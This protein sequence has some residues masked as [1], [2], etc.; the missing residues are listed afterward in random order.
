SRRMATPRCL[1]ESVERDFQVTAT[2]ALWGRRP[3]SCEVYLEGRQ[4]QRRNRKAPIA[5]GAQLDEFSLVAVL[6][7][8]IARVLGGN[9]A[10]PSGLPAVWTVVM[11]REESR[12]ARQPQNPLN[13]PPKL[14]SIT[15]REIGSRCPRIGHEEGIVNEGRVPHDVGDRTESMTGGQQYR[16][17]HL[18]NFE[19]FS[20]CK[21]TIPLRPVQRDPVRQIVNSFP[22]LPNP[23]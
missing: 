4:H 8:Q 7:M 14:P 20:I 22:I 9:G 13:A 10:L 3:T 16:D 11:P 6:Q 15:S 12:V 19:S 2:V 21:Q 17:L 1:R 5:F 18:T 23:S